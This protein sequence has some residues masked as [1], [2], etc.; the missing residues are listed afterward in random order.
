VSSRLTPARRLEPRDLFPP[1]ERWGWEF[2]PR[3]PVS[4][5]PE[6]DRPPTLR[7]MP[8]PDESWV[9]AALDA[10]ARARPWANRGRWVALA[11]TLLAP[12][13]D[14][15]RLLWMALTG[16]LFYL[17]LQ[18]AMRIRAEV[19]RRRA[20]HAAALQ[21]AQ[22]HHGPARADWQRRVSNYERAEQARYDEAA[23]F[24]PVDPVD[25]Y[26]RLDLCGGVPAGWATFLST[27]GAS[28]LG[29]G[30]DVLVLDLTEEDVSAPLRQ[31]AR[32]TG[33]TLRH[34]D[35]LA[36]PERL[37]L[38]SG[39]SATEAAELLAQALR[40]PRDDGTE[41]R[42]L[43]LDEDLIGR[44]LRVLD[45]PIT[46][47]KLLGGLQIFARRDV[48]TAPLSTDE[49]NRLLQELDAV[50]GDPELRRRLSVVTAR[51]GLLHDVETSDSGT[52][53]PD[54]AAGLSVLTVRDQSER[55]RE[56]ASRLVMLRVL[57][58]VLR[59]GRRGGVL[60]VA[61]ADL[62]GART[63]ETLSR[64]SA[65]AGIRL[66]YLFDHVRDDVIKVV[67]GDESVTLFMR[68]GN[69]DEAEWAAKFV[70][71]EHQ[72]HLSQITAT[73]GDTIT[74]GLSGSAGTSEGVTEGWSTSKG[75]ASGS[76]GNSS[77]TQSRSTTTTQSA[78]D[79]WSN[80]TAHSRQE[81]RTEQRSRELT[82]EP[83]V[84]QQ[85]PTTQF[86]AVIRARGG[87]R[88]V[89]AA[90]CNPGIL[91]LDRVSPTP[92]ELGE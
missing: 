33:R 74:S 29:S 73:A 71:Y 35:A 30:T 67:G 85:L 64:R 76:G 9:P 24:Y 82:I 5:H 44:V 77:V 39:L 12:G 53:E 91:L 42:D 37:R 14:S 49:A 8:A 60:V 2:V 52:V 41:R 28:L 10:A 27:F 61:G 15:G 3:A 21:Q 70:G 81:G 57:A 19:A 51:L 46:Y 17:S 32:A 59:S 69:A 88:R 1:R 16:G 66:V 18:P 83:T 87:A 13:S 75:W 80:S 22:A 56:L 47:P 92:R 89:V 4:R 6:H 45:E 38:L 43:A 62:L 86:I 7:P 40:D 36:N 78:T 31:L 34:E 79:T 23:E 25:A 55:R 58:R 48:G 72:F 11:L 20:A 84:L 65:R 63:L 68:L 54:F 26:P 90:D 50:A